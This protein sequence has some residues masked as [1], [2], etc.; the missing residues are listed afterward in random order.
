MRKIVDAVGPCGLRPGARGDHFT[1]LA[2][3][4]CG[5]QLSARAAETIWRRFCALHGDPKRIRPDD[6]LALDDGPIR[7][8]G[9]ST[10][11]T[12]S[13]KDLAQKV[14]DGE[15]RLSRIGRLPDEGIVAELTKVRGIGR[16]TAEMFLLFRLGRPDVWPVDDLGIRNAVRRHYGV[17][18]DG[19]VEVAQPWRPWRSVASWYLWRSLDI[20][21]L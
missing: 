9:M 7:A 10:A 15:V 6:V 21:A 4:I 16:W 14:A 18:D 2:R 17:E 13:V 11:K 12:A 5:Q 20:T 19:L 3:A 1:T 8:T